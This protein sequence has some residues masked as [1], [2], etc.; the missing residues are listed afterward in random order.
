MAMSPP[1]LEEMLRIVVRRYRL[2]A[3]DGTAARMREGG[4]ATALAMAIKKAREAKVRGEAPGPELKRIFIEALARM[5]QEAMR[6]DA[7]DPAFQA[8]VLRQQATQVREYASLSAHAEQDRRLVRAMVDAIAHPAKRRRLAQDGQDENLAKIYALAS[9]ASWTE[10]FDA[11]QAIRAMPE[12][13]GGS[14][15]ERGLAKLL[16]S[17]ALERLRRLEVLA[18][19]ELVRRYQSL[20]DRH[21]PRSGSPTAFAQGSVSKQ[22]GAA[23]EALA[24]RAIE[25]LA[26]RLNERET[27]APYRVVTSMRVPASLPGS[28]HRAKSEWDVVL[29]RRVQSTEPTPAWKVCLLVEAKAS[30]DAAASDLPRLLRGLRL[31]AQAE[32]NAVYPFWTE[33]GT[34]QLLGSSLRALRHDEAGLAGAVLYCCDAPADAAP[35]LLGAASR[36]QLLSATASLEFAGSLAEKHDA[37]LQSLEP[38]WHQLLDSPSWGAVLHQSAMLRQVRELMVH[39]GDLEDAIRHASGRPSFSA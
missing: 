5:I 20:W 9:G 27:G 4:P 26:R 11:S 28:A 24:A 25:A 16:D 23:V 32:G 13:A 3:K 12:M 14:S 31:L 22:R 39:T 1:L 21:G 29:L 10:L 6:P 7:G 2:P 15:L 38:I 33:Q 35:R 37:D 18:S 30:L 19:D 8:M 17:P 36:M 34:M